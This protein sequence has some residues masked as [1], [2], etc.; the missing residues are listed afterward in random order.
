MIHG[1]KTGEMKLDNT[2]RALTKDFVSL[3]VSGLKKWNQ[4]YDYD[5]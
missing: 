5:K 4:A 3:I 2:K 1:L